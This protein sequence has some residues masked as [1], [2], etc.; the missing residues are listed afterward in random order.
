M[1]ANV[2]VLLALLPSL[3]WLGKK[4]ARHASLINAY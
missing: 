1:F 3:A 4:H 2:F